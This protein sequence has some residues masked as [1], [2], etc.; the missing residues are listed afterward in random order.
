MSNIFQTYSTNIE[1][2]ETTLTVENLQ[3]IIDS[4]FP[5]LYYALSNFTN[6]DNIYKVA[7]GEWNPEYIIF[8]P[9]DF[10]KVR[11]MFPDRRLVDIKDE[12]QEKR[13]EKIKL[14]LDKQL[15]SN[16]EAFKFRWDS[17]WMSL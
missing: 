1:S 16:E 8:H 3:E 4:M 12:P 9:N 15:E 11:M 13:L 14:H 10:E 6:Q 7:E 17:C 2:E 5:V